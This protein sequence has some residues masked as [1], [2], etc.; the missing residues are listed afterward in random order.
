MSLFRVEIS[1]DRLKV[2]AVAV[3]AGTDKAVAARDLPRALGALGVRH[4]FVE[5]ALAGLMSAAEGAVEGARVLVA[6]GQPARAGADGRLE[7]IVDASNRA[8]YAEKADGSLDFRETNLVHA[9]R[10]GE[11]LAVVHPPA[12]GVPGRNVFG[13]ALPAKA[14]SP[15]RLQLGPNV[16]AGSGSRQL[17]AKAA[18]RVLFDGV[19]LSV[20]PVMTVPGDVDY[21]VGNIRFPGF[22][23]VRGSVLDGFEVEA[24]RGVEIG[25]VAGACTVRSDGDVTVR[26][27]VNGHNKAVIEAGG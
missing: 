21:S 24:A 12:A 18:G 22:L 17:V 23:T 25:G 14:G 8:Q 19:K 27:G 6:E 3:K 9:V 16:A 20:E 2:H 26:G 11:A 4:G 1:S 5:D 10:E 15:A 7:F 13:E